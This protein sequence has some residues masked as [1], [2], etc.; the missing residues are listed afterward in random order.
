MVSPH[1]RESLVFLER[2]LSDSFISLKGRSFREETVPRRCHC[3]KVVPKALD[4]NYDWQD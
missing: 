1:L 4:R 2:F 3:P